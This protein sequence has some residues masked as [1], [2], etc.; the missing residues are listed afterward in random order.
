MVDGAAMPP[1][2]ALPL[3]LQSLSSRNAVTLPHSTFDA[4]AAHLIAGLR[5]VLDKKH[6]SNGVDIS[7][8]R[9]PAAESRQILRQELELLARRQASSRAVASTV[10]ELSRLLPVDDSDANPQNERTLRALIARLRWRSFAVV[11]EHIREVLRDRFLLETDSGTWIGFALTSETFPSNADE[12]QADVVVRKGCLLLRPDERG[13]VGS[14]AVVAGVTEG[15][16]AG[17][18]PT[19]ATTVVLGLGLQLGEVEPSQYH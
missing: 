17:V 13:R 19:V 18:T 11:D 14:V 16:N 1:R 15:R 4:A 12:W 3:A 2:E 8:P 6:D 7:S 9:E 10:D 5:A